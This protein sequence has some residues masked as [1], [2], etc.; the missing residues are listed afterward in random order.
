VERFL[1][2]QEAYETLS[3]PE[4]RRQYDRKLER[5]HQDEYIP[6]Y[7][8]AV[9]PASVPWMEVILSPWEARRGISIP[10]NIDLP[11]VCP[12]CGGRGFLR[13]FPCIDCGG[14]GRLYHSVSEILRIPP[15]VRDG[16][17]LYWRLGGSSTRICVLI[18]VAKVDLDIW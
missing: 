8:P 15:G 3:D 6:S 14:S 1:K 9:G 2:I 16:T 7:R 18:R 11:F 10:V 5:R 4:K 17:R 13:F 12:G